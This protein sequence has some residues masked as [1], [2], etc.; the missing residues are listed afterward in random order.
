MGKIHIPN[1][2]N[3]YVKK[4]QKFAYVG[5]RLEGIPILHMFRRS[6]MWEVA[7][8]V[9]SHFKGRPQQ[10]ALI[11]MDAVAKM[12]PTAFESIGIYQQLHVRAMTLFKDWCN[13]KTEE[14]KVADMRLLNYYRDG[15][16]P[17]SIRTCI[18]EGEDAVIEMFQ[19]A[20]PSVATRLKLNIGKLIVGTPYPYAKL[21]IEAYLKHYQ[22]NPAVAQV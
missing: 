18:E 3:E 15:D 8:C 20:F 14:E 21:Q 11:T 19:K 17:R 9:E 10:L 6:G 7:E 12:K 5:Y 4:Y 1:V 13:K 22:G 2:I 16:D